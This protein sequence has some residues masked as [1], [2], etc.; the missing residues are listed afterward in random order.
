MPYADPEAQR[1]RNRRYYQA[2][3]ERL[4]AAAAQRHA[5]DPDRQREW[6]RKYDGSEKGKARAAAGYQANRA[7]RDARARE[8]NA[9]HPDARREAQR[10]Y[11]Q[12]PKAKAAHASRQRARAAGCEGFV[13]KLAIWERDGGVC[14][15]CREA[16]DLSDWHLD[17]VIPLSRGGA[18]SP[19]NTQ[20]AHPVCNLKKGAKLCP[21]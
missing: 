1:E 17:H 13:D 19:E 6:A 21:T 4:I 20:V 11:D 3:R 7:E 2:N 16:A 8:W 12:K 15:I 18:H 5:A 10:R 14:G 9:T